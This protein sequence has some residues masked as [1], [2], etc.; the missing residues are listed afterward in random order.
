MA[1]VILRWRLLAA[2]WRRRPSVLGELLF[3]AS[4]AF[5]SERLQPSVLGVS[6]LLFSASAAFC[7]R[8]LRPSVL[9][10]GGL[11]FLSLA[12]FYSWCRRPSILSGFLFLASAAFYSRRTLLFSAISAIGLLSQSAI[13]L[14]FFSLMVAKTALAAFCFRRL[15][16][17]VVGLPLFIVC[18]H[19]G[20]F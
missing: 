8:H 18:R 13:G 17:S 15:H 19:L 16:P 4:A 1:A 2:S 9:G 6:D 11:L 5:C 12:A 14:L 10:V 20:V 7:S 3:S